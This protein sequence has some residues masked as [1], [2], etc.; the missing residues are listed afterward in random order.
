MR[1]SKRLSL[2]ALLLLVCT[3]CTASG[4]QPAPNQQ[5][6]VGTSREPQPNS[7]GLPVEAPKELAGEF[8][9]C[10]TKVQP[11]GCVYWDLTESVTDITIRTEPNTSVTVHASGHAI[12]L[13]PADGFWPAGEVRVYGEATT[14]SGSVRSLP[15]GRFTV[16]SY[17]PGNAQLEDAIQRLREAS[18]VQAQYLKGM[19][20]SQPSLRW[21]DEPWADMKGTDLTQRLEEITFRSVSRRFTAIHWREKNEPWWDTIQIGD[22]VWLR[23]APNPGSFTH[24]DKPGPTLMDPLNWEALL[25]LRDVTQVVVGE[26]E[27]IDGHRASVLVM[28]LPSNGPEWSSSAHLWVDK[29]TGRPLRLWKVNA[30][31]YQTAK[32]A[33]GFDV[34]GELTAFTFSDRPSL[35]AGIAGFLESKGVK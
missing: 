9:G 32:K 25:D 19:L 14:A 33:G 7:P 20:L 12:Y 17:G 10:T 1:R 22:S 2:L 30:R 13:I 8:S 27:S 23:Q 16:A 24:L 4:L 6:E 15:D 21:V 35:P 34:S 11:D 28:R 31:A 18:E 5:S 3:G 26:D 29:E